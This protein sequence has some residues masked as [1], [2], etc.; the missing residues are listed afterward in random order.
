MTPFLEFRVWL[1]RGPVGERVV[2]AL[3]AIVAIGLVAWAAVPVTRDGRTETVAATGARDDAAR[4]ADEPDAPAPEAPAAPT[5]TTAAPSG[6]ATAAAP[7]APART[8]AT[9]AAGG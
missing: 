5:A 3:A 1:R 9:T 2:A 6:P 7:A 8:T 4:T